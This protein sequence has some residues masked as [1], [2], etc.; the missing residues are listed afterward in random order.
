MENTSEDGAGTST[1]TRRRPGRPRKRLEVEEVDRVTFD[2]VDMSNHEVMVD[3]KDAHEEQESGTMWKKQAAKDL[4]LKMPEFKGKKGSDPKVHIQ[5]FESWASLRELP[6]T[7]WRVCFPQTLKGIAQTWYFNYPS[8][9]L[10]T[11]KATSK[12]FIQRFNEQTDEELVSQLGKI[13]QKK[14]SVRQFVEE[15]KDLARQ[16][17]SPPGNKSLRAW[18]LNGSS[19]KGLAK[20]EITNPTKSF[21]DLIQRAMKMERKGTKKGRKESSS[22]SSDADS[23][24]NSYDNEPVNKRAKIHDWESE[25]KESFFTFKNYIERCPARELPQVERLSILFIEGLKMKL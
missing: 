18:F 20:A 5:A 3:N 4:K 25:H 13:K 14:S 12:A 21:E 11:Y 2:Q 10:V 19:L 24:S 7:E 17:S 22:K 15:I 8:E 16:L 9:Q 23:S 6:R 1:Q